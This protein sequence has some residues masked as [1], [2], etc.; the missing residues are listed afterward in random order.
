MRASSTDLLNYWKDIPEHELDGFLLKHLRP[1]WIR[2]VI[3]AQTMGLCPNCLRYKFSPSGGVCDTCR[4]ATIVDGVKLKGWQLLAALRKKAVELNPQGIP[5]NPPE[6]GEPTEK[7]KIVGK[8]D[9]PLMAVDEET[10]TALSTAQAYAEQVIEEAQL[11]EKSKEK[12]REAEEEYADMP[13]A[14]DEPEIKIA[15]VFEY[16]EF[17]L[18]LRTYPGGL[19]LMIKEKGLAL[20]NIPNIKGQALAA[21]QDAV[22]RT[23]G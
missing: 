4:K 7:T 20:I 11:R 3:P 21:F 10:G 17:D 2:D 23:I 13:P 18:E 19:D 14:A 16:P 5:E 6:D 15:T 12:K 1:Y 22:S 8:I 9:L